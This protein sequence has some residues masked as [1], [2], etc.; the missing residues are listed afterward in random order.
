MADVPSQIAGY[1]LGARLG[2]GAMGAVYRATQEALGREVALKLMAPQLAGDEHY[3]E[4]F[5]REARAAA[6]VNH[7]HVVTCFDAGRQDRWLFLAMELMPGGDVEHL[8]AQQGGRLPEGR[9]LALLHDAALGLMGIE[10]AGL[11]HRDLKPANLLLDARGTVKIADL[12]LARQEGQAG[13]TSAGAVMGTPCYMAPEQARGQAD[14]D[15]R[16]DLWALGATL[17]QLLSGRPPFSGEGVLDTIAK[18]VQEPVPDLRRACPSAGEATVAI[19]ARC[20]EKDRARRY[21]HAEELAADLAR[22]LGRPVPTTRSIPIQ[23]DHGPS[24]T[25]TPTPAERGPASTRT[26][27]TPS[28]LVR[29][30]GTD[31]T[32]QQ[33]AI[34][35]KRVLIDEAG[36]TAI[37]VLGPGATFVRALLERILAVAGVVHGLRDEGIIAAARPAP[38]A[39]RLVLARGDEPAPGMAGR[40]VRGERLDALTTPVVVRISDDG[41]QAVALTAFGSLVPPRPLEEALRASGV[42][43]GLDAMAVRRLMEGPA[44]GDGRTVIATGRTALPGHAAGFVLVDNVTNTTVHE[45]AD[46]RLRRVTAGQVVARWRDGTPGTAGYD[47]R[48]LVLPCDPLPATRPDAL[49]GEG[50][51]LARDGEGRVVLRAL[52]DGCCQRQADGAVR[53]VDVLDVAGDLT[54]AGGPLVTDRLVVVHGSIQAG[55]SVETASDVVVLGDI[56]DARVIAGG[57]IEVD[58][59]IL[60]GEAG[61]MAGG[62]VTA[63]GTRLRRIM[64]A[65]VRIAGLVEASEVIATGSITAHRVMGGSL[66]AAGDIT[67]DLAGDRHGGSTTLWAGHHLALDQHLSI[68]DL[69]ARRLAGE[70]ERLLAACQTL[71]RAQDDAARRQLRLG[72]GGFVRPDVLRALRDRLARLDQE[73]AHANAAAEGARQHLARARQLAADLAPMVDNAK[74]HLEVR[75]LAHPGTILRLGDLPPDIVTE[76]RVGVR[77]G[78]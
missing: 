53:V 62:L 59:Q 68:A 17:F 61:V 2:A 76:P 14:Q 4:R 33:L 11:I 69:E 35:A 42:R 38:N 25:R 56:H 6:R 52:L 21:H 60:S 12:G 39:R 44:S 15:I 66:T 43:A 55:A 49:C 75:V 20:L 29:M 28:G 51:E 32:S 74:A 58:G 19:L 71:E 72:S 1:R 10:Q 67:V 65:S 24:T 77:V 13:A 31:A 30:L 16:A 34:L 22:A 18:V 70:R 3:C 40:S 73:H 64:A 23:A 47:V 36:L 57:N 5:L 48:G 78:A 41:M 8:L 7:P 54:I 27:V 45:V 26:P 46:G 50:I 63:C 37:L 9:A